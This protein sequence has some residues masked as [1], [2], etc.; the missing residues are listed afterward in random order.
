MRLRASVRSCDTSRHPRYFP[1]GSRTAKYRI[2]TRR[3]C[4]SIQKSAWSRSRLRNDSRTSTTLPTLWGGW[5]LRT[6]LPTTETAR[7]KMRSFVWLK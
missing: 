2:Q 5:Q 4:R 3:P 6:F 7:G 1:S